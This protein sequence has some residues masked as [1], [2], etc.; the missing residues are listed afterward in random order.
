MTDHKPDKTP[1]FSPFAIWD[2]MFKLASGSLAAMARTQQATLEA[3]ANGLQ[4][5]ANA[6]ARLWGQPAHDVL[7]S[8]RRF[9]HDAWRDNPAFD[10]LKQAYLITAKWMVDMTAGL[11]E[12]DPALHRRAEFW[13]QQLANALSPSN[14]ALTNPEVLQEIIRTGGLN[15]VTGMQNLIADVQQG[16]LSQVPTDSFELGKDLACTPGK[17]VY[18]SPLIEL[19]QYAPATA[20]VYPVPMLMIPPWINKYYVMDMEPDNSLYQHLVEAGFTVYTISWKNPDESILDLEWD[21]YVEQGVLD[22]LRVVQAI[23]GAKK[24]NL[25][26]YCLGGIVLQTSLAYLAAIGEDQAANTATFF[27]THQ[28]FTD[29]GDIAVF[30]SEPEVRFLEWLMEASGGYLDSR[31][32]A[33]TFN[34]LR[35]NDLLWSYFVNNYLLG[36]TPDAFSLLYWN[37]DGTRVPGRVHSFL[38]RELFLENKL[39]DPGGI[40]VRGVDIDVGRIT[41]PAYAVTAI[42]DHIVPWRGAFQVRE[43]MGGPVRFI[44]TEGGHIAGVIN[45][46]HRKHKRAHWINDESDTANPDEWLAGA[47]KHE[48]SWWIDWVPWLKKRSGKKVAPPPMGN[49]EFPPLMD[50]PGTYVLEK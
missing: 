41:T 7:P 35:S 22:A 45:S 23:T 1:A 49:E 28:D 26:G 24:V 8:D 31:N 6:S 36:K 20:Q 48:E 50:A 25:V 32:L 27:T 13:T 44:L 5:M 47:T 21:D 18:R 4:L 39:K 46:P 14:F 10:L 16:R 43:L 34:M 37:N 42:K 9:A 17:V 15:L 19:I 40:Q 2:S 12:L 38:V 30:I 11:E 3:A 33:Y 29:A